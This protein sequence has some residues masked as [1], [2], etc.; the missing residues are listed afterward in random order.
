MEF[1][2]L[3]TDVLIVGGGTSGVCAAIQAAR[4]GV[5]VTLVAETCWLGG[6]LTAAGVSA[7][8]GN[9]LLPSGLWGEFRNQ[10]H[11]HYGGPAAVATGW[12][13]HT[14]FEP[15]VGA[16]IFDE[17][18]ARETNIQC[19]KEFQFD[20]VLSGPNQVLGAVFSN[21]ANQK[22]SVRA[23]I[24][25]DATEN[26][27][28]LA[29]AGCAFRL[30]R[31]ARRE[32]GEPDAPEQAD[33]LI[34][35]LTY[36]AIL[37]DFGPGTDHTLHKPAD[38]RPTEYYGT[39]SELHAP[40]NP[41]GIDC[42]KML[43]YGELPNKKYMINWPI[44]GNDFY[45]PLTEMSPAD[46][47]RAL[48]AAKNFTLGWIYFLQ[49]EGGFKNLGLADD[50]FP[51]ADKLALIPYIRESRRVNGVETLTTNDLIDPFH[52][53]VFQNGIAVGDYPLDHHHQKAPVPVN[54]SFPPI[55][56]FNV[57]YGC[58]VPEKMDGLLVA[59]KSISVTHLVNGC[60]RLQPVVMQI[61]QAA[62]ASAAL[63][64]RQQIQP[65]DVAVRRLQQLLLDAGMWL[66]PFCD[67]FPADSAFLSI[68]RI[69]LT[70]A[71]RGELIPKDWANEMRFQP[72]REVTR[73]EA[74][75]ALEILAGK[76]VGSR[77]PVS[78][79]PLSR[80]ELIQIVWQR[81]GQPIAALKTV[82]FEDV[83]LENPVFQAVQFGTE[84]GWFSGWSIQQFF[85]VNQKITRREMATLLDVVFQPF[86]I[87]AP[88][89][90]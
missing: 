6:M 16:R 36:V 12:V 21:A 74:V 30:G 38:Y 24:T 59:E 40:E 7:V 65:R 87:H 85:Q 69:G 3:I 39:C 57:P 73:D 81:V 34:Q 75:A 84:N 25:I 52:R 8:D 18:V 76:S 35:D 63:C 62:G 50:E 33:D 71:L 26:G 72:D 46:R 78:N 82:I 23:K 79:T 49:T 17:M 89:N 60:T 4:L 66:M 11:A 31:D 44:H 86:S 54:E 64:V 28:V 2:E 20:D 90:R 80:G 43:N 9:H 42:H 22:L 10:L 5:Q 83:P 47:A 61:G 27:D 55:P 58:L 56:A 88:K 77:T 67:V 15:H 1:N 13:S 45:A 29:R 41:N 68:Q 32:T 37:K 19:F 53:G 14:Q 70:G 51:S 48:V